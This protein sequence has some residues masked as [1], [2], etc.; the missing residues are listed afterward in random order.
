MPKGSSSD[1]YDIKIDEQ[2]NKFLELNHTLTFFLVTG[3]VGTLGFTLAFANEHSSATKA[4]T[5]LLALLL[6]CRQRLVRW[7]GR[8]ARAVRPSSPRPRIR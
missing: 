2:V 6:V 7:R 8:S 3:A 1:E 5:C 4:S